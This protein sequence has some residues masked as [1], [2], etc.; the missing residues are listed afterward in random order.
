MSS[1]VRQHSP[2][3][4]PPALIQVP[5]G[6]A[7]KSVVLSSNGKSFL[8]NSNDRNIRA[9]NFEKLLEGERLPPAK[10]SDEVTRHHW[11]HACFSSAS[12]H[13]I[14]TANLVGNATNA[15]SLL[16]T[17]P[18]RYWLTILPLPS[19]R[20]NQVA[21]GLELELGTLLSPSSP[22]HSAVSLIPPSCSHVFVP[23]I[24]F[25]HPGSLA[26]TPPSSAH[27]FVV[28]CSSSH[29]DFAP[30]P[31]SCCCTLTLFS[32]SCHLH[33][34]S[35]ALLPAS[36]TPLQVETAPTHSFVCQWNRQV[37]NPSTFGIFMAISPQ[38]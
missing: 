2:W 18:A 26:R 29:T 33:P 28:T 32:H 30:M 23:P 5:G 35:L 9:Y 24:D 38:C 12:E 19:L 4:I 8:L 10:L 21:S 6:A 27:H 15:P 20:R 36:P 13:V 1:R 22:N 16:P 3:L 25:C 11:S 7:I 34:P 14:G 31:S 37:T 17:Q